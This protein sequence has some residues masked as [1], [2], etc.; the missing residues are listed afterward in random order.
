MQKRHNAGISSN[1][2]STNQMTK[3]YNKEEVMKE[4]FLKFPNLHKVIHDRSVDDTVAIEVEFE[5]RNFIFNAL[6][7]AEQAGEE[8]MREKVL[9]ELD[10]ERDGDSCE[11]DNCNTFRR[12][13]R[14]QFFKH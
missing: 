3:P 5:M 7:A 4:A 10:K 8:R 1:A 2:T 9:N 11:C 6:T 14:K 12:L 13:Y